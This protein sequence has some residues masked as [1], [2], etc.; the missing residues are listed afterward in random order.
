MQYSPMEIRAQQVVLA[1]LGFYKGPID[2]IWS[3]GSIDAK[4][5]FEF[6]DSFI[7][8]APNNGLPFTLRQKLPKG[9]LW[10]ANGMMTHR[11][12]DADKI[13][14]ILQRQQ[15][16]KPTAVFQAAV[17]KVAQ[18]DVIADDSDVA[19]PAESS[20]HAKK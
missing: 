14:E 11:D 7:P 18:E 1:F 20:K 19:A 3:S 16:Q 17:N 10:D 4:R 2:G 9:C 5:A 13:K 8:A 6:H 12:L 15:K